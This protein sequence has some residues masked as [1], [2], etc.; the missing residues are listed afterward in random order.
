MV[1]A[2]SAT[3]HADPKVACQARSLVVAVSEVVVVVAETSAAQPLNARHAD[4]VNP[5]EPLRLAVVRVGAS[6]M[7]RHIDNFTDLRYGIT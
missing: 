7:I 4:G 5:P 1:A 6:R 2:K 3:G